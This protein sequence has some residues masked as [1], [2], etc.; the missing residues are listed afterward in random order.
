MA[1]DD[2][3]DPNA[4]V[5]PWVNIVIPIISMVIFVVAMVAVYFTPYE[6][7]VKRLD[8]WVRNCC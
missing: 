3:Y 6:I 5:P 2:E 1:D 7:D 4:G 8:L